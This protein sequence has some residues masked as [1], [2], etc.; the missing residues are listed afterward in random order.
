MV[1]G[2]ALTL[3]ALSFSLTTFAQSG[4]FLKSEF[5]PNQ[6]RAPQNKSS[7]ADISFKSND[8]P[9]N[10]FRE[11]YKNLSD[12]AFQAKLQGALERSP[13]MFMRSFVN[14]YYADLSASNNSQNLI[15]C[16]G[17][18]HPEN[19]G[20][21]R[22]GKEQRFVYNDIDD[23]G[24]CP[25]EY[26]ILRYF[27]TV[28][29]TFK[30]KA[31]TKEL[32]HAYSEILSGRL[33]APALPKDLYPK[34]MDQRIEK[35][36]QK[37]TENNLFVVNKKT[38]PLP[39]SERKRIKNILEKNSF[40]K[41][42]D[43]LDINAVDRES[44]GSGGLKRYWAFVQN[45]KDKTPDILELKETTLPGT[46]YGSWEQPPWSPSER[47]VQIIKYV[48]GQA[49]YHFGV[50]TLDNANYL[51]RSRD[52]DSVDLDNLKKKSDL[53]AYLMAQVGIIASYH[54]N[55]VVSEIPHLNSWI[56]KNSLALAD[57]YSRSFKSF[58]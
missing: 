19:F 4:S 12:S 1:R 15:L 34:N 53:R 21:M 13:L 14:T 30:D 51:I 43:I 3:L 11:T 32:A 58:E 7:L 54:R 22:F 57:R 40:F 27:A 36:V 23:T 39:E 44:G 47:L 18:L 46:S 9:Q 50:M 2:T 56:E 26:D 52:K 49:P 6:N 35:T 5:A 37:L 31:L 25:L 17:D 45:K 48:W 42:L 28:D 20:F 41:D 16:L 38:T 55:F 8:I 33:A 24:V 10:L 29:L